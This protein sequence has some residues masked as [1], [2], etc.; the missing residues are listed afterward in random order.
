MPLPLEYLQEIVTAIQ[1]VL[2]DSDLHPQQKV[3][4]NHIQKITNELQTALTPV[5][6]TELALRTIL[7]P[8]V[9]L[10]RC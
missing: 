6:Q 8:G 10:R 1:A 4:V 7:P 3:F 9:L 2:I 5:P